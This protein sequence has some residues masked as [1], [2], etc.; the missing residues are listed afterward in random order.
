MATPCASCQSCPHP[1]DPRPAPATDADWAE[2]LAALPVDVESTA[3]ASQALRRRRQVRSGADLLRLVLLY[4]LW[5]WPLRLVAA[6]ATITGWAELSD[7]AL[8]QRLRG[9]QH[10]LGVLVAACLLTSRTLQPTG[11]VRLRLV[12]ATVISRPGS[13]GTDWRLHVSFDVGQWAIDG[14]ELTDAHGGETLVRHAA[15][16]GDIL[17]GDRGYAHRRGV[18]CVLAQGGALVLRCNVTNL[19]LQDAGGA[20][21]DLLAWLRQVPEDAP[22]ERPVQ[23]VTLE[24]TFPLRLLATRLSPQAADAARRRLRRQAKKKG[25]TP[26]RRSLEAAGFLLLVSTLDPTTWSTEQVLGLYRIRWQVELL[27]KRLKGLLHLDQLRARGAA[28]AQVYLLGTVLGA[29]LVER[30]SRGAPSAALVWFATVER[31][32]SPWRWLA[33]WHEAVRQAVRGVLALATMQAALPKLGRYLCDGPRRRLQQGAV[34]RHLL[35]GLGAPSSSAL[36][37]TLHTQHASY[38][39]AA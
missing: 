30:V 38:P 36:C 34:A 5:D 6:W 2:L 28:L 21:L 3:R 33:W 20:P 15:Q 8:L 26:D 9:A 22:A 19:P 31:P 25:H 12:D 17:V 4:S 35:R 10:Y 23:I 37:R 27:F 39:M 11:P 14:L 7:V 1:G 16:P 13:R 18:G 24:G 32:V 29:L